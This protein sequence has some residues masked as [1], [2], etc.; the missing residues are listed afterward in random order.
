MKNAR[1]R[2]RCIAAVERPLAGQHLVQD[3]AKRPDIGTPIHRFAAR[4]FRTH[5]RRRS[6]HRVW[7]SLWVRLSGEACNAEVQHLHAPVSANLYVAWLE[8]AMDDAAFVC[9]L[10]RLGNLQRDA[11]CISYPQAARSSCLLADPFGECLAIDQLEHE[12]AGPVA[13]GDPI[14]GPD[15]RVVEGGEQ[16]RFALDALAKLI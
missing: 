8:I 5:V 14:D 15:V 12:S 1:E 7:W 10:E 2:F 9:G 11:Q 6:K 3:A 13:M 4:L 16:P